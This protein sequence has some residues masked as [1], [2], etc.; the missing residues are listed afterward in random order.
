MSSFTPS[1]VSIWKD[2]RKRVGLKRLSLF[3]VGLVLFMAGMVAG[4]SAPVMRSDWAAVYGTVTAVQQ[5]NTV[6]DPEFNNFYEFNV[7]ARKYSGVEPHVYSRRSIGDRV[8][9]WYEIT[10]PNNN[11][12]LVYGRNLLISG[13]V[14]ALIGAGAMWGTASKKETEV[15]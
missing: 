9:V 7:G 5:T 11:H 8:Q 6:G 10:N 14:A 2:S 3:T 12:G 4:A 15:M 13:G 1:V